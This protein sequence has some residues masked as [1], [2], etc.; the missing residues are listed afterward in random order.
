MDLQ[1]LLILQH[2]LDRHINTEHPPVKGENRLFLKCMALFVEAGECLNEHRS[3]KFWS[4]DREPRTKV[5][6][7]PVSSSLGIFPEYKNPLL[8]EFADMLSFALGIAND[9]GASSLVKWQSS[10]IYREDSVD[11]LFHFFF[12]TL[13]EITNEALNNYQHTPNVEML[14]QMLHAIARAFGFTDEQVKEA[15]EVKNK[16]NHT[17]QETGY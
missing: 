14:F 4:V 13:N 2:D 6:K 1:P 16:I 10:E 8:E 11:E 9:T 12:Y 7:N 3:F 15:Y 17:R 5:L